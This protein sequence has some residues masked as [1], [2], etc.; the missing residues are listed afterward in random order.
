MKKI[1]GWKIIRLMLKIPPNKVEIPIKLD[2]KKQRRKIKQE[3]KKH[4]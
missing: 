1:K 3:L 4:E 2:A